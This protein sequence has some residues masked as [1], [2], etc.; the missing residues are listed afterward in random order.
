[1]LMTASPGRKNETWI[2]EFV[3]THG[4][5]GDNDPGKLML[6]DTLRIECYKHTVG[7]GKIMTKSGACSHPM[8]EYGGMW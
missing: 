1:M 3:L 2:K 5:R 6:P 7:P 4:L 8:G